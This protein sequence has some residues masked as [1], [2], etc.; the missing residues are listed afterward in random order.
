M[1]IIAGAL[2]GRK[3]DSPKGSLT[4]PMSEKMR[5][6]LFNALGDITGLNILDAFAGSG[7]ISF[8]AISRGADHSLAVDIDKRALDCIKTNIKNLGLQGRIA[9]VQS[10]IGGLEMVG[11][12]PPTGF[13]LVIADPPYNDIKENLLLKVAEATEPGG[14]LVLSLP[15]K[16]DIGFLPTS[17]KLL[18][19]KTY[20]DSQLVFYKRI[21]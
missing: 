12:A 10:G 21:A 4:H 16:Y 1:R 3:F 11:L 5:G 19:Q 15:P 6:A 2:G 13:D 9:V 8:E 20:G 17:F 18:K 7:A 14:L